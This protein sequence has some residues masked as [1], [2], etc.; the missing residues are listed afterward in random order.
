ML[1]KHFKISN[2]IVASCSNFQTPCFIL[3]LLQTP[4]PLI[5]P[6]WTFLLL[7]FLG[8]DPFLRWIHYFSDVIYNWG[9]EWYI[10]QKLPYLT[11]H[12]FFFFPK[13]SRLLKNTHILFH[14]I[15]KVKSMSTFLVCTSQSDL[16]LP[17]NKKNNCWLI[18][19][20]NIEKYF[21]EIKILRP[22]K[23]FQK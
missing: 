14:F 21:L 20:L 11:H 8:G 23:S 1:S 17:S 15:L 9:Q 7:F 10:P 13:I 3:S 6:E 12:S 2:L 5:T 18:K 4:P 19:N 16:G 22:F